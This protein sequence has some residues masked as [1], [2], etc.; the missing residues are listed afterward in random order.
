MFLC[1]KLIKNVITN[2]LE[3][4]LHRVFGD[5]QIIRIPNVKYSHGIEPN[6]TRTSSLPG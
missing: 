1:W 5:I 4:Y 3:Y 6:N 2:Q